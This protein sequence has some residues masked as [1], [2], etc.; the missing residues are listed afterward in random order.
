MKRRFGTR[1][2]RAFHRDTAAKDEAASLREDLRRRHSRIVERGRVELPD[3]RT[4]E[5]SRGKCFLR[6]L[7]YPLDHLHGAVPLDKMFDV[8]RPRLSTLAKDPE[9]EHVGFDQ[10]LFLDT[11]TT[12]LSGGA[13][14]V[15]FMVGM[16]FLE[17]QHLVVEQTFL[18]SFSEEPAALTH[19]AER[20]RQFPHLVTFVGKSFDRH[21]LAARMVVHKVRSQILLAPHLDLYYLARRAWRD[22][23]PD[24]RLQTLEKHKLGMFRRE[25]LPGAAAP[26]AFLDWIADGSGPVDRIFEHNLLDVLSLVALLGELGKCQD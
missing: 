26:V 2:R 1:L 12:G 5:N 16:G 7:R 18:R 10:C 13:G 14:T 22:E 25:D 21:R 11:E 3:G 20:L 17:G 23:L 8:D 4:L 9:V 19:V 24:V 6:E 15:V